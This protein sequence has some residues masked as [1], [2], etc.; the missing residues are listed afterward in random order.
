MT[1]TFQSLLGSLRAQAGPVRTTQLPVTWSVNLEAHVMLFLSASLHSVWT[2]LF[3]SCCFTNTPNMLPPQG[4][5]TCCSF[6][7]GNSSRYLPDFLNTFHSLF[8]CHL[9]TRLLTMLK[10][11]CLP[12]SYTYFT[13][14][15]PAQPLS[16]VSSPG[17][18]LLAS[19][20]TNSFW[21]TVGCQ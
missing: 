4:L 17:F 18:D 1:K 21:C 12:C 5:C 13:L 14:P 19:A 16:L 2:P 11:A 10:V 20:L 7:L 8:K 6:C 3:P 15:C 9:L